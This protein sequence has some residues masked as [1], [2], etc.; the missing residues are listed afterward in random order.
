M[1]PSP[2]L[3][4]ELPPRKRKSRAEER[5]AYDDTSKGN[6]E[7]ETVASQTG[8]VEVPT[9]TG[10]SVSNTAPEEPPLK[11]PSEITGLLSNDKELTKTL[12]IHDHVDT[13]SER[14]PNDSTA[15]E[16]PIDSQTEL[17]LLNKEEQAAADYTSCCSNKP[18][19]APIPNRMDH[20]FNLTDNDSRFVAIMPE[21]YSDGFRVAQEKA[22]NRTFIFGERYSRKIPGQKPEHGFIFLQALVVIGPSDSDDSADSCENLSPINLVFCREDQVKAFEDKLGK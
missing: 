12:P 17:P 13:N 14:P 7:V 11:R 22:T 10:Q 8:D 1:K 18:G 21:L 20:G 3:A 9:P 19:I 5:K 15:M 4:T 2:I 6:E 16:K